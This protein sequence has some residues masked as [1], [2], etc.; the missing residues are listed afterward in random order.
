MEDK[1]YLI[2]C[3]SKI[4]DKRFLINKKAAHILGASG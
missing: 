3:L 4:T 1:N 2:G